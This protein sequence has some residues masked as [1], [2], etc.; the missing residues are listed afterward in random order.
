MHS[1]TAAIARLQTHSLAAGVPTRARARA[2]ASPRSST[3]RAAQRQRLGGFRLQREVAQHIAHQRLRQQ[4]LAESPA[5]AGMVQRLHQGLAQQRGAA[6]HAI[7]AGG[8]GHLQQH[9]RA[10]PGFADHDAPRVLEL[11]LGAGIAVIA[12]L[13]L[14]A[15]DADRVARA[16]RNPARH[17][18]AAKALVG[19]R[20]HQMG[21]IRGTEKNHLWPTSK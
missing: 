18:K 15:P 17:Q 19:L 1:A 4:R 10:A 7:E 2:P 3:A 6:Q 11:H 14:Q 8:G 16:F 21:V 20:Q 9:R 13:V 12:Q 5:V